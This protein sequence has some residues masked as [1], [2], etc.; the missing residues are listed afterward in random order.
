MRMRLFLPLT[1][2]IGWSVLAPLDPALAADGVVVMDESGY[3]RHCSRFGVNRYSPAALKAEGKEV[4]SEKGFERLKRDTERYLRQKGL[5]PAAV[6]W[7]ENVFH[8]LA[9]NFTPQLAAPPSPGWAAASFD[10]SEWVLH[11]RPFQGSRPADITRL[12]LGQYSETMDMCLLHSYYRTRLVVDDSATAGLIVRVTYHGGARVLLNGQEI[13]RGHLP[14]GQLAD[15]VRGDDYPKEAY[16]ENGA[17]LRDRSIGP[18]I[19]P[20]G[21]VRKGVNVLAIE[22]HASDFHPVV[23]TNPTQPNWGGPTRPWP[24]GQLCRVEVRGAAAAVKSAISRPAGVQ[25]WIADMNR[26]VQSD[27]FLPPGETAAAAR[28]VGARNGTYCAQVVI[29]TDRPLSG[30]T[31]A[32]GELKQAGGQGTIPTSAIRVSYPIPFPEDQWTLKHLGDERGLNASFPDA[33]TLDAF[34]A[35]EGPART[36]VFDALGTVPPTLIPPNTARSVWLNLKIPVKTPA[37]TYRGVV[38]VACKGVTTVDVPIEVTVV[39]WTLPASKDFQTL[40]GC[41][42]NP[43][44]VARQYGVKV[45]SDE[46]FQLIATSLA[47]LAR[48]GNMWVNV[49]VLVNTEYGNRDDSMIRWTHKKNDTWSFDYVILDR[50]LE[51][52]MKHCGRPRVINVVLMQGFKSQTTPP[53]PGR[54]KFLDEAT[55]KTAMLDMDCTANAPDSVAAWQAFARSLQAHM[56]QKGLDKAL[57]W[58]HPLESEA[59]PRLKEVLAEATP[60]VFWIAGPHEMMANGTYAKKE[61][62]YKLIE[63]IRYAGNWPSFRKDQGWRSKTTHLLNPRVGGTI[64]ALH[65]TS[66]P[67]AYRVMPDHAVAFGRNGFTRVGADEWAGVHYDGSEVVKWETGIP[68]LFLLWPGKDG[69]ESSVR[70]EALLEGLQEAEARIV[71][72]QAIECGG[73]DA[74]L[75]AKVKK[76][77]A[78]NLQEAMFFQGNSMIRAFEGYYYGW[79]RRSARLYEAAADVARAV[80]K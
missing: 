18:V 49:P 64:F 30:L 41:E 12:N 46:H 73:L 19:V 68:V 77:L 10:D 47:Q 39:D 80:K 48:I 35:M 65:T 7:M 45:W 17:E 62:F 25:V 69:A 28:L 1:I 52:V 53:V 40:V 8:P 43:Y 76:V 29:G 38:K 26:R 58:G 23:L 4:L 56:K 15:D 60:N 22:I 9:V 14:A 27:D 71:L 16:A 67:F 42:E 57:F 44:G 66:Q 70:F 13:A 54:I 31:V 33:K 74:D 5:D 32:P 6:D 59:D 3:F 50:Y 2:T 75:E 34:A 20:S 24:H 11:R 63:T 61:E 51:L 36:Y 78:D 37:G 55:G 72:E 79:Q 21:L